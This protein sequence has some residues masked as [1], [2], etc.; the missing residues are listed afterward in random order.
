MMD[1]IIAF[2]IGVCV[3]AVSCVVIVTIVDIRRK[4]VS[5]SQK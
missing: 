5:K 1:A 4:H 3:Y 2:V